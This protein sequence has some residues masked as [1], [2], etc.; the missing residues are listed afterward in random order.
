MGEKK[1]TAHDEAVQSS[2]G[3]VWKGLKR[4]MVEQPGECGIYGGRKAVFD[5]HS[6][7]YVLIISVISKNRARKQTISSNFTTTTLYSFML[8]GK[9][10][11][12]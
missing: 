11:N 10:D 3:R 4:K 2:K 7:R 8:H 6:L 9:K 12:S 1:S 5:S